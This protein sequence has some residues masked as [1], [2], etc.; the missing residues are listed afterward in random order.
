MVARGLPDPD[1][2]IGCHRTYARGL[3][4]ENSGSQ[5]EGQRFPGRRPPW[6][7]ASTP[8]ASLVFEIAESRCGSF[9]P[10]LFNR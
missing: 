1:R 7:S 10:W 6:N 4:D 9:P 5:P 8:V 2:S 3:V